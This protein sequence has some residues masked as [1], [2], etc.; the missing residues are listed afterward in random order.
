MHS[1]KSF[2]IK[3]FKKLPLGVGTLLV[4][5]SGSLLLVAHIKQE[6]LTEKEEEID[7]AILK[8]L[9]ANV[10]NSHI[11][12]FMKG[13]TYMASA[14]F[15]K[16]AYSVIVLYKLGN[17]NWKRAMEIA[18]TGIGGFIITYLMKLTFHRRRPPHPLINPL[19]NFSFPSGHAISGFIFYGLLAY[20]L[21][22]TNLS[23]SEKKWL[24][25]F[26]IFLALL[27]GFSRVYLRLHYPSD[28]AAGLLIG[29]AWLILSVWVFEKLKKKSDRELKQKNQNLLLNPKGN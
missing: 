17:R 25:A 21:W 6:V 29:F 10:I 1:S 8:F 12:L 23:P 16:M 18:L 27:I 22:K 9:S 20:L 14:N 11:T 3:Y 28:V 15:L 24:A 5:F 26:L 19:V 7:N 13:I 4:F 2:N